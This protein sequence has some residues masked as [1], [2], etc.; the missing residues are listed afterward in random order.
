MEQT[1]SAGAD[2]TGEAGWLVRS[3]HGPGRNR[4]KLDTPVGAYAPR[5]FRKFVTRTPFMVNFS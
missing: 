3:R 2:F 5:K 4:S 1:T